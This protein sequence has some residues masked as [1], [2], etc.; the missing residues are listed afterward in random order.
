[1]QSGL[2]KCT[3]YLNLLLKN[4]TL[5][6]ALAISTKLRPCF[7]QL[8]SF[9]EESKLQPRCWAYT[10]LVFCALY[11]STIRAQSAIA[12][13]LCNQQKKTFNLFHLK[14]VDHFLNACSL[15]LASFIYLIWSPNSTC[16]NYV[17]PAITWARQCSGNALNLYSEDVEFKFCSR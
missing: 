4:N 6:S 10:R 8:T 2:Q 12:E 14:T 1:M 7:R 5:N 16:F 11:L 9:H 13:P 3:D 17:W 15:F